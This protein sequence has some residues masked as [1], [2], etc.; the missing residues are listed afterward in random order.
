MNMLSFLK[1]LMIIHESL[2]FVFQCI[3][4]SC[5][6]HNCHVLTLFNLKFDKILVL[7]GS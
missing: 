7:P 5:R 2:I 4:K 3:T 6:A 1:K